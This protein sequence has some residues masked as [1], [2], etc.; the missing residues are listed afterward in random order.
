MSSPSR[1]L[2]S[3]HGSPLP[4]QILPYTNSLSCNNLTYR[5]E[6]ESEDLKRPRSAQC[7]SVSKTTSSDLSGILSCYR[8]SINNINIVR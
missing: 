4:S 2:R 3:K 7:H 1:L 6:E 5:R 8:L